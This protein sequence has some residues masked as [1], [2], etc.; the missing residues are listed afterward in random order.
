MPTWLVFLAHLLSWL[1]YSHARAI[2]AEDDSTSELTPAEI[3]GIA[4]GS[5]AGLVLISGVVYKTF[6]STSSGS[7]LGQ[8]LL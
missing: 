5:T 2:V 7:V 4:V 6:I 1:I 3:A 8:Q